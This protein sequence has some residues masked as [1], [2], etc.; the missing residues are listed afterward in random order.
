MMRERIRLNS[1]SFFTAGTCRQQPE[2]PLVGG[3]VNALWSFPKMSCDSLG[4]WTKQVLVASREK[5]FMLFFALLYLMKHFPVL[6]KLTASSRRTA[7]P[8]LIQPQG[9]FLTPRAIQT[10]AF[11]DTYLDV[12][13]VFN[14]VFG[15][16]K[17][18][19]GWFG[20]STIVACRC[21][22]LIDV[23]LIN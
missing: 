10:T 8:L 18:I 12:R 1:E 9:D 14:T 21:F 13:S 17:A 16:I 11:W 2:A 19:F 15:K 3:R 6:I 5:P 22:L 20:Q 23:K 4:C 7:W